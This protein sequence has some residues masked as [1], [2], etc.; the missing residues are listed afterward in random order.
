M[1]IAG[2]GPFSKPLFLRYNRACFVRGLRGVVLLA[3]TWEG[4]KAGS[5]GEVTAAVVLVSKSE[6]KEEGKLSE[7]GMEWGCESCDGGVFWSM[8]FVEWLRR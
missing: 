7:R 5:G 6:G 8:V 1:I 2:G 3:C 4:T